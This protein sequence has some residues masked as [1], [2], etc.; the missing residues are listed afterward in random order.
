MKIVLRNNFKKHGHSVTNSSNDGQV[1]RFAMYERGTVKVYH[2]YAYDGTPIK[3]RDYDDE[4][5]N[6]I[7]EEGTWSDYD[8]IPDND[9]EEEGT[10]SN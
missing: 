6:D 3:S 5:D 4:P 10:S 1:E 9:A 7:E 8:D 2:K